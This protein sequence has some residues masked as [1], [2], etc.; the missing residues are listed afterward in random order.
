MSKEGKIEYYYDSGQKVEIALAEDFM[1]IIPSALDSKEFPE[2]EKS[3]IISKG[4]LLQKDVVFLESSNFSKDLWGEIKATGSFYPVYRFGYT[5]MVSLSEIRIEDSRPDTIDRV[6]EWA[7]SNNVR[8]TYSKDDTELIIS[9]Y[10][11]EHSTL[12]LAN[13]LYEELELES[14]QPNFIRIES[15]LEDN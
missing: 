10:S 13:K 1:A 9:P 3:N 8:A 11:S 4:T 12:A 5:L 2:K 14:V 15:F 7:Q 6:L